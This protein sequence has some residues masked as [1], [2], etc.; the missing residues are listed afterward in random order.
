MQPYGIGEPGGPL[1]LYVLP[2][3]KEGDLKM[4]Q[5]ER[6]KGKGL[7]KRDYPR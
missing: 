1:A 4:L 6:P 7:G 2:L 5:L 3:E